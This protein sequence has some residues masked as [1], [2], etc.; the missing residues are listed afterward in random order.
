[1]KHQPF[2]LG[3]LAVLVAFALPSLGAIPQSEHDALMALYNATGGASW[4]HRDNWGNPLG[5]EGAWYGVTLDLAETTVVGLNL[6]GN[7]LVGVIPTEIGNLPNLES[8]NLYDNSLSGTPPSQIGTLHHLKSLSLGSNSFPDGPIWDW[9][10]NLTELESLYLNYGK[11]T[12]PLP[13]WIG[14]L[15]KLQYIQMNDNAIT[16]PIPVEIAQLKDLRSFYMDRCQFSGSIPAELGSLANLARIYLASN[17][18]S[19]AIPPELGNLT[20][21]SYLGLGGNQLTGPIPADLDRCAA[22]SD[23]YLDDNALDPGPIPEWLR[24]H[25]NLG[26]LGLNR[27]GRTGNLPPWLPELTKLYY[28][29]LTGN[30]LHGTIP[31]GLGDITGLWILRLGDNRLTGAVPADIGNL[32]QLWRLDL[33]A[34]GLSGELPGNLANLGALTDGSGLDLRYNALFTPDPALKTFLDTKQTEGGDWLGTQTLAPATFAVSSVTETSAHFSWTP[35]A[36]QQET[37]GY[38]IVATVNGSDPQPLFSVQSKVA[39]WLDGAT[40]QPSTEYGFAVRSFTDASP[41]NRNRVFS[42][43]CA[44]VPITTPGPPVVTGLDPAS[45]PSWG[46]TSV[47]ISGINLFGATVVRFG[48]LDATSFSVDSETRIMAVN[49]AQGAGTVDVTVI[50]PNGTSS[51]GPASKFAYRPCEITCE[52]SSPGEGLIAVPVA[53]QAQALATDCQGTVAFLWAFGDGSTSTEQNQQHAYA[54][55]GVFSWTLTATIAG[56]TCTRSGTVIIHP[57]E[58]TCTA[59]APSSAKQGEEASFTAQASVSH[60]AGDIQFLWDFGDGS[61][62][63]SQNPQ[64]AYTLTGTFT[65]TMT[66]VAGGISCMKMGLVEVSPAIPGDC[67]GSGTVSIGEVQK[68][69]NMFLEII[70]PNCGVDCNGDGTVSIG[71]VQKVIIGFLGLPSSC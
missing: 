40:L 18:L 12:G 66:V 11:R 13:P 70:P 10:Q 55:A 24:N 21:L 43:P 49:P 8:L 26:A 62:S 38:Q 31:A 65:W 5:T 58:V 61:T 25:K 28:I 39:S 37:G 54:T 44:V 50:N 9:I 48:A 60:C 47:T 56:A 71:E 29:L 17:Q 3:F 16:G 2:G 35:M 1:M 68:A 33:S 22:L 53:F 42:D 34:N 7:H 63:T 15:T 67:D 20:Q 19:G 59:S 51:T 36:Y 4:N 69:I 6:R 23:L 45:G 30:D 27:T 41:H 14:A 32:S 57:C 52:A 46:G 64:H